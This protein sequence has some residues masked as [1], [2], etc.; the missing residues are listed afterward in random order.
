MSI[1]L[2]L[3]AKLINFEEIRAIMARLFNSEVFHKSFGGNSEGI[4]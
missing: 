1:L 3:T 2:E 4:F